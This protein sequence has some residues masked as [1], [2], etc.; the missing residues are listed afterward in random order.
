MVG[1]I[2]QE[3]NE[4]NKNLIRMLTPFDGKHRIFGM[5]ANDAPFWTMKTTILLSKACSIL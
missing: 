1:Q 2:Q 3:K 5:N 4:N